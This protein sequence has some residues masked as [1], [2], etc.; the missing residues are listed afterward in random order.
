MCQGLNIQ[1]CYN[2]PVS[3]PPVHH[4]HDWARHS[5]YGAGQSKFGHGSRIAGSWISSAAISIW[6][7]VM[8]QYDRDYAIWGRVAG[9]D[10]ERGAKCKPWSRAGGRRGFRQ[11]IGC[12]IKKKALKECAAWSCR[13]DRKGGIGRETEEHYACREE[14][15]INERK[16]LNLCTR[17]E[18]KGIIE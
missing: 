11:I 8:W 3:D 1:P 13:V 16:Q 4:W 15:W 14:S 2:Q 17:T 5:C 7:P 9:A 6:T 18:K 12:W 10:N